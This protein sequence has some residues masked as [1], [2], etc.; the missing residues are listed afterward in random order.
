MNQN[1]FHYRGVRKQA[2]ISKEKVAQLT[3]KVQEGL[4]GDNASLEPARRAATMAYIAETPME[5]GLLVSVDVHDSNK[6]L[7]EVYE[8]AAKL[9]AA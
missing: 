1:C 8:V 4:A 3:G 6:L 9:R 5:H 2:Y 7:L